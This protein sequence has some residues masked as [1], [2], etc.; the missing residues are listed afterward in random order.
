[1]AKLIDNFELSSFDYCCKMCGRR[2]AV[3]L[4]QIIVRV[5]M[6]SL[7]KARKSYL[8]SRSKRGCRR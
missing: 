2:R 6:L 8:R 4:L 5:M 7:R 1:M 3:S